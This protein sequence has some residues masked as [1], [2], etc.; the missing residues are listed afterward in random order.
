M[1]AEKNSMPTEMPSRSA[2]IT[3]MMLGGMRMPRHDDAAM[4]PADSSGL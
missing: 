4:V 3:S 1:T 2:M